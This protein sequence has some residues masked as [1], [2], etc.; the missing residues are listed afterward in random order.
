VAESQG[1]FTTSDTSDRI[2][3]DKMVLHPKFYMG[4]VVVSDSVPKG[5]IWEVLDR[6]FLDAAIGMRRR[7]SL[8]PSRT[9]R[10]LMRQRYPMTSRMVR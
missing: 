4:T 2:N 7:F 5:G 3:A 1:T 6:K 8:G 10:A 9:M